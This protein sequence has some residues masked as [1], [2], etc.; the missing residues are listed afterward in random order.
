M[1]LIKLILLLSLLLAL[2]TT[3]TTP[4]PTI[5]KM[6]KSKNE[7]PN[8]KLKAFSK[9]EV[10]DYITNERNSGPRRQID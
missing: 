8:Y 6:P 7:V 5:R 4:T 2:G 9:F 3:Q 10:P 1:I